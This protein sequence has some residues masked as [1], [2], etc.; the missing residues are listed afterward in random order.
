MGQP[1]GFPWHGPGD[2]KECPQSYTMA[3]PCADAP[4]Q[5]GYG[6]QA[7]VTD[8]WALQISW[9]ACFVCSWRHS[10]LLVAGQSEGILRQA[11]GFTGKV[12]RQFMLAQ[13]SGQLPEC[14][15]HLVKALETS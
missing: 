10:V 2:R 6:H 4:F 1:E 14:M 7:R 12:A 3:K 11:V 8:A 9:V 15:R 13:H 5:A